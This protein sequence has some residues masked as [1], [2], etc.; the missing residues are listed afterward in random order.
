[1]SKNAAIAFCLIASIGALA[2]AVASTRDGL[3]EF[4][5]AQ[6]KTFETGKAD[7]VLSLRSLQGSEVTK[8]LGA[9][10]TVDHSWDHDAIFLVWSSQR[11]WRDVAI[12]ESVSGYL[13]LQKFVKAQAETTGIDSSKPF[14]FLV[15]GAP[16]KIKWHINVDKSESKPITQELFAKSKASY[17]I[18]GEQV[19][20]IGF[21]SEH[22]PGVFITRYTPAIQPDSGQTN[23]LHIHF[24]SR[25]G[26]A[27]GHVDD[28]T[29]GSGMVL[30]LPVVP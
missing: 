5:G 8:V 20:M 28:M 25:K 7:A 3:V 26:E 18:E 15:A 22:H 24:V 6:S 11:K 30:R 16:K 21:Y 27:A 1:V 9:S 23:A 12:P 19:D 29:L 10:Y 17:I 14:P 4:I 2:A 13:E